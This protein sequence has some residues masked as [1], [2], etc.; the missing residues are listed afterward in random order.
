MGKLQF[1]IGKLSLV[2][3]CCSIIVNRV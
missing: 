3:N 1:R 2:L